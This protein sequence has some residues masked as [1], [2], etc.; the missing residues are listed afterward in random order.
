VSVE[1]PIDG[2]V[3]SSGY[4]HL[5]GRTDSNGD[6]QVDVDLDGAN[7]SPDRLNVAARYV[8]GGW[9]ALVQTQKYFSRD[10]KGSDPRNSF[11]GYTLTDASLRFDTERLGAFSLSAQNVF[12][13]QY[14]DYN[15]DTQ[16]PTDNLRYFA[17]RGRTWT[18]GWSTS[19]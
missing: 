16:R 14:I 9:S 3:L 1:T 6:G 7:I 8:V 12:D 2:L 17:G 5:L 15:S 10:F 4:A 18:L 11:G 13:E 19:F